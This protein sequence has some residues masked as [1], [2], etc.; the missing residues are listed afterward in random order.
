MNHLPESCP[1]C[2]GKERALE[3]T[4]LQGERKEKRRLYREREERENRGQNGKKKERE[5]EAGI[6][7]TNREEWVLPEGWG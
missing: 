4:R 1:L 3:M 7:D 5:V 6:G 2:H